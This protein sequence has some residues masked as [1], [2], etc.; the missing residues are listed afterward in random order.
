M[1]GSA[2]LLLAAC[3][4]FLSGDRSVDGN[5]LMAVWAWPSAV[6]GQGA[7]TQVVTA[8]A[9]VQFA[10]PEYARFAKFQAQARLAAKHAT[11]NSAAVL[12]FQAAQLSL[13]PPPQLNAVAGSGI[14][15]GPVPMPFWGAHVGSTAATVVSQA[16]PS[17]GVVQQPWTTSNGGAVFLGQPHSFVPAMGTQQPNWGP[18]SSPSMS[19]SVT[20]E[21]DSSKPVR[22]V[23]RGFGGPAS[24]QPTVTVQR[25]MATHDEIADLEGKLK[26]M[27]LV[28]GGEFKILYKKLKSLDA[29][30]QEREEGAPPKPVEMPGEVD[31][32]VRLWPANAPAGVNMARGAL[33]KAHDLL[34]TS[35]ALSKYQYVDSPEGG[36][37][38]VAGGA[39]GGA[40]EPQAGETPGDDQERR[41]DEEEPREE[42]GEEEARGGEEERREEEEPREGGRE[43]EE[44]PREERGNE[45]EPRE[46]RGE[47][48]TRGGEEERREEE[49]PREGGREEEEEPREERGEEEARGGEEERREEEEPREGG[50][51][52]EEEPREERGNEEEPREERGE[53]ETR[54]GEEERREEEEPREGGRE[55]EEEPREERGDEEEPRE[56][57]G[58]EETRGGEEERREEEEPREGGREEEE[59]PREERGNEEEP[60]EERGEEEARGGE[61]ERREEEPRQERGEGDAREEREGGEDRPRGDEPR[62]AVR[63]EESSSG[64]ARGIG[65]PYYEPDARQ[66]HTERDRGMWGGPPEGRVEPASGRFRDEATA[67]NERMHTAVGWLGDPR[68]EDTH[69]VRGLPQ[70]WTDDCISQPAVG[71]E[72]PRRHG[73]HA[74]GLARRAERRA[75]AR[76]IEDEEGFSGG[77]RREGARGGRGRSEL[78]WRYA[79]EAEGGPA[80]L[81]KHDRFA[82]FVPPERRT[83]PEKP[84]Y[85]ESNLYYDD[86]GKDD[87]N[88]L[89]GKWREDPLGLPSMPGISYDA[90]G[91]GTDSAERKGEQAAGTEAEG[92]ATRSAPQA[93]AEVRP[94]A[95][96]GRDGEGFLSSLGGTWGHDGAV[97]PP[98]AR[99]KGAG[100]LPDLTGFGDPE[101]LM[102][103]YRPPPPPPPL[104]S[105][106]AASLAPY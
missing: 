76:G 20:P 17:V 49:E 23:A 81:G 22:V 55:E 67:R 71:G 94:G 16:V 5:S 13:P 32:G 34:D 59:E 44:E 45:E 64:P 11:A 53:E 57:R 27:D 54:G 35:D 80:A 86:K 6:Q 82:H 3:A 51:E 1:A 56:E 9:P 62:G 70:K 38:G 78:Q 83:E 12:H 61:E 85:D 74:Q 100:A 60:R 68:R 105:G 102:S 58:E 41:E 28:N 26:R 48:E 24:V 33:G 18:A 65:T 97:H 106:H 4:V 40:V 73:G 37:V 66:A 31:S 10:G 99:S 84:E 89:W 52:E 36:A 96:G 46:E 39:N 42:R 79:S 95:H 92:A 98:R 69:A 90:P 19:I 104:V 43:E 30:V 77:A 7:A 25:S 14:V 91:A 93:L 21:T 15:T 72:E 87:P 47:E 75:P 103:G 2:V 50:R 8:S 88:G 63:R 101:A 29:V